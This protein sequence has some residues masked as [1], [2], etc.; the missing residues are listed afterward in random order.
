MSCK[1]IL[2]LTPSVPNFKRAIQIDRMCTFRKLCTCSAIEFQV[3]LNRFSSHFLRIFFLSFSV[4][5]FISQSD[6]VTAQAHGT[7]SYFLKR[8]ELYRTAELRADKSWIRKKCVTLRYNGLEME[9]QSDFYYE[10]IKFISWKNP[11]TVKVACRN[12]YT[13]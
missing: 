11:P 4:T 3:L 13:Y 6:S 9:N 2:I 8:R 5:D 12:N 10:H 7:L 1:L